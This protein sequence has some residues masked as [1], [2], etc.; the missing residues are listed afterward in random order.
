LATSQL[1][2]AA[3]SA[4]KVTDQSQTI[5]GENLTEFSRKIKEMELQTHILKMEKDMENARQRLFDLR[6]LEYNKNSS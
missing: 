1:V 5:D 6:K 2:E 4:I 3:K